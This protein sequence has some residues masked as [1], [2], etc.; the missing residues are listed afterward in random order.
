MVARTHLLLKKRASR[1]VAEEED[2]VEDDDAFNEIVVKSSK[3]LVK[4]IV[5][6][7]QIVSMGIESF[8]KEDRS[9]L[10][11]VEESCETFSKKAKK[12][13]DKV[14]SIVQ[15]I[16]ENSVDNSHFYVQMMEHKREM[17]H[18]VHFMLSPMI[19]HIENNHKPFTAE[20]NEELVHLASLIDSF[21]NYVLHTVKEEKFEELDNLII[22]RDKIFETLH[23]N[24]KNQIKRIKNKLV[25]TR[26]SQLFFKINTEVES[27]LRHTVNLVKSQRDFIT[28]TQQIK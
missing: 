13:K 17:A 3:Q 23:Q 27:L 16:T 14:Y 26:N 9:G 20:Q 4:A 11:V 18:A 1:K 25:N 8:L 22:E 7:N 19:V 28:Y 6:T 24:E 10:K 2:T 15:K 12:N 21:Y 5:S